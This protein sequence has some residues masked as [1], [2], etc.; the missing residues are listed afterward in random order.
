MIEE[1]PH[2]SHLKSQQTGPSEFCHFRFANREALA[3]GFSW[4][5]LK[6]P[7]AHQKNWLDSLVRSVVR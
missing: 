2:F 1:T 5:I 6:S 3:G 4:K 7:P